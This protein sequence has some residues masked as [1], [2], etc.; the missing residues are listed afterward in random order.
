MVVG[1]HFE[2]SSI[3]G[4]FTVGWT[5]HHSSAADAEVRKSLG[6]EHLTWEKTPLRALGK[7]PV[8]GEKSC[9]CLQIDFFGE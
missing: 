9:L 5:D 4:H 7:L 6:E 2:M 8:T 1:G 3:P